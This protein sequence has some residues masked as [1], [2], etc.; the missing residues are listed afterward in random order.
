MTFQSYGVTSPKLF[1]DDN[2]SIKIFIIVHNDKLTVCSVQLCNVYNTIHRNSMFEY[3]I[4]V[5]LK[6]KGNTIIY[7]YNVPIVHL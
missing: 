3:F 2:I 7:T 4:I 1:E 5:L 6:S